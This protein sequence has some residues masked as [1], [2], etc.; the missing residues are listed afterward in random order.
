MS[1]CFETF[2]Q[3]HDKFK[4]LV[5]L[6][7]NKSS[8]P[9]FALLSAHSFI[10]KPGDVGNVQHEKCVD[11]GAINYLMSGVEGMMTFEQ[12]LT[13]T[14]L[15]QNLVTATSVELVVEGAISFQ[16]MFKE[17]FDNPYCVIFL[18]NAKFFVV[19]VRPDMFC[20]RDCHETFQYNFATRNELV[21]HLM[22]VYNFCEQM[23]IEG[24]VS[25]ELSQFNNIEFLVIEKPFTVSLDPTIIING[26]NDGQYV[27]FDEADELEK[28]LDTDFVDEL[29]EGEL[30]NDPDELVIDL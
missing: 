21:E 20:V 25:D 10:N 13:F 11:Q 27:E 15:N 18:K 23:N 30:D 7:Y 28:N 14:N 26:I 9:M 3:Y 17:E 29:V 8:C 16:H 5:K 2:T 19:Y 6:G 12:M 1:S 4:E 24:F 22:K